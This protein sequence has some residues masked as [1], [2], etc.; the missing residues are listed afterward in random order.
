MAARAWGR[1]VTTN[2]EGV[3]FGGWQECS[4]QWRQLHNP[5]KTLKTTELYTLKERV[6]SV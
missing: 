6:F 4:R 2:K 5:V 3:S 1:E